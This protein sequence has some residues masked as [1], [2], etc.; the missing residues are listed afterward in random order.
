MYDCCMTTVLPQ[1]VKTHTLTHTP[2]INNRPACKVEIIN[3]HPCTLRDTC[4]SL[5]RSTKTDH[6][7]IVIVYTQIRSMAFSIHF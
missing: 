2:T 4:I 1:H 3:A 6:I 5:R 7:T